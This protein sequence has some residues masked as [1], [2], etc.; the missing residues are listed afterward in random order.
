[1]YSSASSAKPLFK[2][3]AHTHTTRCAPHVPPEPGGGDAHKYS[4]HLQEVLSILNVFLSSSDGDDPVIGAG[5]GLV[6]R[7][8]RAGLVADVP[9]AAAAL[10]DDGARKVFGNADLGGRGLLLSKHHT[11]L[12]H[13]TLQ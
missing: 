13:V 4:P 2:G 8:A 6:Y 7:D 5:E 3:T 10:A 12:T 9:D 1:M 11:L